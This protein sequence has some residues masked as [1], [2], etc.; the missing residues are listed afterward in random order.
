MES[1]ENCQRIAIYEVTAFSISVYFVTVRTCT[2]KSVGSS[3]KN[4]SKIDSIALYITL[5]VIFNT[6]EL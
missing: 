4:S 1:R 5:E 6:T 2:V 3:C